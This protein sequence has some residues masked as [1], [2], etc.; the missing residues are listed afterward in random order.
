MK[1]DI[2]ALEGGTPVRSTSLPYATQWIGDEEIQEVVKVLQSPWITSGPIVEKFEK[3]FSESVGSLHA[4]AV[5]SGTAALHLSVRA[6]G[7]GAGDEVITTP[8]TFAATA[9][10][11]LH[12]GAYPIFADVNEDTFNISPAEIEQKITLKTRAVIPM[13]YAGNPCDMDEITK[14]AAEHKLFVIEDAAHAIGAAYQGKNIGAISD[15][16]CFSLHAIKNITSGEGGMIATDDEDLAKKIISLRFFGITAD[17]WKRAQSDRPWFYEIHDTGF[18]CNMMD[19]Q[20]AI[21]LV[22]LRRLPEFQE[23]RKKIVETYDQAFASEE[24]IITPATTPGSVSSLHL[25]VIRLRSEM[26]RVDRDHIL[27]ALRA[28]NVNANIHYLPLHLHPYFRRTY[29]F[30][31]GDFPT[32]EK[33]YQSIITLPLFPKMTDDDVQSVINALLKIIK[34]YRK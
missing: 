3:A 8:L 14:I 27:R 34:Y 32:A 2:P 5:S 6:L 20:A 31:E 12:N 24:T 30:K 16:T 1:S 22:Q 15:L 7:I 17:A 13:H 23:R 11:I 33:I 26:L 28:E 19:L 29:N 25:Y 21:G 9:F 10:A 4:V 18:K